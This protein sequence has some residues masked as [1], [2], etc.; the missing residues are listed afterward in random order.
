[1]KTMQNQSGVDNF[2]EIRQTALRLEILRALAIIICLVIGVR[3]WWMQVMNHNNYTE[4]A[5]QNRTRMLSIPAP[6]GTIYDRKGRILVTSRNSFN[7]TLRRQKN[8]KLEDRI[9]LIVTTLKVDRDWLT[10][11]FEAAKFEPK[12]E[13]IVVKELATPEDVIWVDSH[14]ME[15]PDLSV[16]AAPQ[17]LYPHGQM[18]AHALG[19]VGEVSKKELTDPNSLFNESKGFKLGDLIGKSGV[20]RYYN[21]ILMGRDGTREVIVDSRG[22]V[23]SVFSETMPIPGRDLTVSLDL[24]LQQT[25]E[26]QGNTMPEGRGS[27]VGMDPNNGEIFFIVSRP[28]FDPNVFSQRAKTSEGKEEIASLYVDEDKPLY[29]RVIQGTFAPGS[30]W[31]LMTTV[32]ALNEG[33]I[34]PENSKIQDGSIQLGSYFMHSMSSLGY[35]DAVTAIARSADGYFYRLGLKMGGERFEKWVR[36]FRFGEKTFIDLPN[37]RAGR[38]PTPSEKQQYYEAV[39]R[40][41]R[42]KKEEKGETWTERDTSQAEFAKRWTDYDMASSAFGQGRNE[43]TPIQ[44]L[45]YVGSLA[46]GGQNYTPHLLLKVA[47]GHDR[48]DDQ[49]AELRFRDDN[50]FVVPMSP[51]IHDI[52]KK[53]MWGA[54]NGAGTAGNAQIQGFEV[55]GKTG[56]AQVAAKST[57]KDNAWF[58]GFAPRDKPEICVVIL[59]ENAGFGGKQSAP[60]AKAVLETYYRRT[61]GLPLE[62]A[63]NAGQ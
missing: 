59:T 19:Y 55:C 15:Y 7:I 28:A 3:L 47:P 21:E 50:K 45:R 46:M 61:R 20:E 27:L 39:A 51:A 38:P 25:A 29:N 10:R 57:V 11:R 12:Y 49:Q 62:M 1:M 34:T 5:E 44:L 33:V 32:A 31:K 40:N 24:D 36:I 18:A 43:A 8:L 42:K 22:R 13:D 56:T 63:K 37:E 52:V 35:P 53:G 48:N 14:D 17:R 26:E 16:M 23:Q 54:V 4:Q 30:T 60:R 6:R 41:A 9:D 2:E 58:I